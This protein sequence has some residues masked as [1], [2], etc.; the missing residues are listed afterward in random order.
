[1]KYN[2]PK[3]FRVIPHRETLEVLILLRG[4]LGTII[5]DLM[6]EKVNFW[7]SLNVNKHQV[8]GPFFLAPLIVVKTP[9]PADE[10]KS[11]TLSNHCVPV[12]L[13]WLERT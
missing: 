12:T 1:M 7:G 5:V 9:P 2:S 3:P 8:Q 13:L 11:I 6:V 4:I 10:G